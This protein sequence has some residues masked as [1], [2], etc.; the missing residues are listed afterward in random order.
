MIRCIIV[1]DEPLAL[2]VL[3]S[4]ICRSPQL[5]LVEQC[6]NALR[7]FQVLHSEK[8]DL[9]FLDIKM[10]GMNGLD[11]MRSL[12][13]PPPVIFT[14]AYADHA[15]IG[16]ELEAVDYLLKPVTY[17]R[18]QK[19]VD[20]LLKLYQPT[21]GLQKD[22]TYFKVSGKLI[23][24]QHSELLYAQS[25]K[26]Y[27]HLYTTHGNFLTH[28]TMKYLDKLLPAQVFIRVHR[29]FLVNK[30]HIS[31]MDKNS[32]KIG[33]VSIPVGENYRDDIKSSTEF[34]GGLG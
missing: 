1:D 10:P 18:F 29:S 31:V 27:I 4:Y 21:T 22:Y 30:A 19:S 11:F 25:V 6:S 16:F 13:S 34:S 24:V 14:T 26:D 9:I 32:L 20:R 15:L 12:K 33:V 17:E 7:A 28:M 8:I 2:E 23:K 3:E 5:E